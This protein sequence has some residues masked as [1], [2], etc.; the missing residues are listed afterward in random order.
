MHD[1][2]TYPT[3]LGCTEAPSNGGVALLLRRGQSGAKLNELTRQSTF[4]LIL[5]SMGRPSHLKH[6]RE[7]RIH[8]P[9]Y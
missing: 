2:L 8:H 1:A 4:I 5:F 6:I 3:R 7:S 9:G